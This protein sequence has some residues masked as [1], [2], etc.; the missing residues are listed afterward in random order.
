MTTKLNCLTDPRQL[1]G[2]AAM[3]LVVGVPVFFLY[4]AGGSSEGG[5]GLLPRNDA[6]FCSFIAAFSFSSGYLVTVA[7][8]VAPETVPQRHRAAVANQCTIA[9][10]G[11]FAAALLLALVI[12]PL[13]FP[14]S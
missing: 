7:S 1:L 13:L 4:I 10:Q 9:F 8:Q 11:A 3:R 14:D 6:I 12:R 5:G 2:A